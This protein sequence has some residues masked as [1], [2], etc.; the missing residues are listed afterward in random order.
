MTDRLDELK[1]AVKQAVG[2]ATGNED[3]A[4]QGEAEQ[5]AGK[6]SR[7]TKGAADQ[8]AGGAK[9]G[10]GDVLHDARLRAEGE[11]QKAKGTSQSAR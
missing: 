5:T 10:M 2:E 8:A 7:T 3:L 6:A 1:G 4:A 9:A 11:A